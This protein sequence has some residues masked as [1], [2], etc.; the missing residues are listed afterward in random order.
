M[1]RN[2]MIM[3]WNDT[4]QND[5][6]EFVILPEGDYTFTVTGFDTPT[7]PARPSCRPATRLRSR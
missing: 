7:S 1:E 5:S 3:D 6:Q 4:I 2:S